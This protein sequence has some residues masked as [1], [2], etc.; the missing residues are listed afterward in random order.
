MGR[1][2]SLKKDEKGIVSI[3]VTVILILVM[4]LI[5]L[6]MARNSAR[7]Q[8]QALDR[9]LSDQ[10]FYN[11]ESGIND[12][13]DY[14]FKNSSSIT[15]PDRKITCQAEGLPAGTFPNP[16]PDNKIDGPNG[17]NKYT[18][19][20]YDKAPQNI[21]IS[22]LSTSESK[23]MPITPISSGGVA[24]SDLTISWKNSVGST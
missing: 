14:L 5:V 7:E 6:G 16:Q 24:L 20:L 17:A 21:L 10:A 11:A 2:L 22:S 1:Q 18:C 3:I 9:Q 19:L 4:T 15:I 8:R 13:A 12:W 23:V